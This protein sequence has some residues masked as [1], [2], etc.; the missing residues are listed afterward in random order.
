MN[1]LAI[2]SFVGSTS[3]LVDDVRAMPKDAKFEISDVD[4]A[5]LVLL[6]ADVITMSE[7]LPSAEAIAITNGR[8]L[9]VGS[10][11]DARQFIGDKTKVLDLNGKTVVPGF[12]DTH[13]HGIARGLLK[14]S[15]VWV[16]L[17]D[18]NSI[19]EMVEKVRRMVLKTP[20]GKWVLGRGWIS[21]E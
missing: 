2:K 4:L 1:F 20:K 11:E 3:L 21:S 15:K 18:C 5:D 19:A 12:I 13:H 8:I 14:T 6:N 7:K 16:D 17:F 10:N 9:K